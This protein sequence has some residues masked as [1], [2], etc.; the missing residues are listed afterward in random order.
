[1]AV[2]E[3]FGDL[4]KS[5][6]RTSGRKLFVQEKVS[7]SSGS[8]TAIQ[9]YVRV[10]PPARVNFSTEDIASAD[11]TAE[12]NCPVAKKSRFCKHIWAT[13]LSVEEKYPDFLLGKSGINKVEAS[14][15]PSANESAKPSYQ[16]AANLRASTYRKEQYQK[17]KTRA[18]D[19]KRERKG[20]GKEAA[21]QNDYPPEVQAALAYFTDNGFE[22]PEG[23][24]KDIMTEAKRKL[25]RFFHPDKGGSHDE[26]VELNKHC[27]II[28]A[29]I[30]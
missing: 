30:R 22:M 25:S 12:C 4:F 17:Q 24:S 18:K 7:I 10:A 6:L 9:A 15:T 19:Q 26:S 11:F 14:A 21:P 1:M 13:L 5:E 23:P 16:E 29:F 3:Q 2:E 20:L 28:L 8:E 27:E